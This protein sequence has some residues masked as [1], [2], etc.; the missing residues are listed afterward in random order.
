VRV[1]SFLWRWLMSHV[2]GIFLFIN[3]PEPSLLPLSS[4]L[5]LS[6]CEGKVYR[7]DAYRLI[8]NCERLKKDRKYGKVAP[9]WDVFKVTV[10]F[11]SS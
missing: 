5:H 9:K 8:K 11:S 4:T 3:I 6:S 2:D 1:L 10:G 7:G